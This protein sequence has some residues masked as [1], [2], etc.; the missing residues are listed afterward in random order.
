MCLIIIIII[1]FDGIEQREVKDRL[2]KRIPEVKVLT[3]ISE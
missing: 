1:N 3:V 2:T